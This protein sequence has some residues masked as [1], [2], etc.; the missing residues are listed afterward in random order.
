MKV[1]RN[2]PC[3]CGSGKKYK[4]CCLGNENS[5]LRLAVSSFKI[6]M[7]A[8]GPKVRDL[9]GTP[10]LKEWMERALRT[11][12]FNDRED[13]ERVIEEAMET[14]NQVIEK[15]NA[16][17]PKFYGIYLQELYQHLREGR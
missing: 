17:L 11:A 14:Y 7:G 16:R 15:V 2:Q 6:E 13:V 3:P 10:D 4:K 5:P 9:Q 8:F 12:Y 1:G